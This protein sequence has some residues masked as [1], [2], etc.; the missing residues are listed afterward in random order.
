MTDKLKTKIK[1][2]KLLIMDVDG[3]LTNG[4]IIIDGHGKETKQFNVYD[5]FGV[6]LLHHAG[7]KTAVLSARSADAV[8]TRAVDLKISKICQDAKPKTTAYAEIL[9]SLNVTDEQTCFI[10]DD[11]PDICVLKKV[12]FAVTVSN[13][14]AEVKKHADY[15]TKKE[16]GRG[17]VR[18][19]VELIL[20]TQGKWNG[21]VKSYS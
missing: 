6:V 15:I 2:I 12:G 17:A 5:G 16:G 20:K 18:E 7:L 11:L 13:A 10:G 1:K 8:T 4:E 14:R 3:V 21:I 9:Q 19:L